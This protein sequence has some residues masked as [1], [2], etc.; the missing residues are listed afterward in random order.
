MQPQALIYF[1]ISYEHLEPAFI[2]IGLQ[3]FWLFLQWQFHL[4]LSR[5]WFSGKTP[6]ADFIRFTPLVHD[7]HK[8]VTMRL[9]RP[10]GL[11]PSMQKVTIF[12]V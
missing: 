7:M 10:S 6:L 3:I 8:T 11:L 2:Q 12:Q 4:A 5:W 1:D 9:R